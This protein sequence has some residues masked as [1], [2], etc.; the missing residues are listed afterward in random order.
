MIQQYDEKGKIFTDVIS[1]RPVSVI[2]QTLFHQI[3][4]EIYIKPDERI[5]DELNDAEDLIA[6][7]NAS[8]QDNQNQQVLRCSFLLVNRSQIIWLAPGEEII[9]TDQDLSI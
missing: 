3:R 5:K 7:T 6:V 9:P 1:K 4:G 2:I 8:I